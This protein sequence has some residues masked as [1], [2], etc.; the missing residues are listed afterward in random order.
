M[1]NNP[2]NR[3]ILIVG[4]SKK[5]DRYANLAQQ[6][7]MEKGY[8]VFPVSTK[9]DEILGIKTCARISD[10]TKPVDTV[11]LYVGPARQPDLIAQI[12]ALKPG[13][14]IF[15]PGTENPAAYAALDNAGIN[16]EE[17]CTLVLLRTG[18]F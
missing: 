15:N 6:L 2:A 10:V 1:K 5:E 12:V 18:Q 11:T 7:L 8:P 16:Y 4:A 13:R 9:D 3:N 17:A 14:V